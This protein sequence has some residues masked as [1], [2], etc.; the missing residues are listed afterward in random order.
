MEKPA[1]AETS[2][3]ALVTFTLNLQ[4]RG[5]GSSMVDWKRR[6]PD[7][8]GSWCKSQFVD[9]IT[10]A[11]KQSIIEACLGENHYVVFI[12]HLLYL[13]SIRTVIPP[14][15]LRCH[16]SDFGPFVNRAHLH[17][18]GRAL[19]GPLPH[20]RVPAILVDMSCSHLLPSLSHAVLK[21]ASRRF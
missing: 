9:A 11:D 15:S 2:I 20:K 12:Q 10:S 7:I 4:P 5:L 8:Q 18:L 19:P 3:K 17:H 13:E 6:T 21:Q 1:R 14:T 16:F